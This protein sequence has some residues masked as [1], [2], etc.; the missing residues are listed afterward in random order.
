[1]SGIR[2]TIDFNEDKDNPL[3]IEVY[4]DSIAFRQCIDYEDHSFITFSYPEVKKL[5]GILENILRS[6]KCQ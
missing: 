6:K 2:K 5:I 3:E 1:M 4:N